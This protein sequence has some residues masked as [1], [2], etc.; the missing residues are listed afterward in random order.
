MHR[1]GLWGWVAS[2]ALATAACGSGGRQLPASGDCTLPSVTNTDTITF[3][4]R[5]AR[6]E[7][8]ITEADRPVTFTA[9]QP[10]ESLLAATM[11]TEP[12]DNALI[13]FTV[14]GLSSFPASAL[15]AASRVAGERAAQAPAWLDRLAAGEAQVRALVREGGLG[16]P[17]PTGR[18]WRA[19]TVEPAVGSTRN[20]WIFTDLAAQTQAQITAVL[21]VVSPHAY[22]YVHDVDSAG[23]DAA[24]LENLAAK[25]ESTIYPRLIQTFG[26]EP[27]VDGNGRVIVLLSHHVG[28]KDL[29]GLFIPP[30][31][32]ADDTTALRRSNEAEIF[33]VTTP[34]AVGATACEATAELLPAILAHELEHLINFNERVLVRHASQEDV[35]ADEGLAMLAQD[36]AGYGHTT[37]DVASR[38]AS[39][40]RIVSGYSLTRWEDHAAGNYGGSYL[41]FR[42]LADRFG[43]GIIGPLVQTPLTG[44]ANVQAATGGMPF[45][46]LERDWRLALALSH[47]AIVPVEREP[48]Y[49]FST[50]NL[51]DYFRVPLGYHVGLF[52][53]NGGILNL[54]VR[55][56]GANYVLMGPGTG[57]NVTLTVTA[58]FITPRVVVIRH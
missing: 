42:Y 34:A 43:E 54:T 22:V 56:H 7:I 51:N 36:I 14:T 4:T 11:N 13:Q 38:I 30:D 18:S 25:W 15:T 2:L 10:S 8:S 50:L 26:T 47:T 40:L 31:L 53:W 5:P 16:R 3:A 28:D 6:E 24:L 58:P 39:Y 29:L 33:Y 57:A 21:R 37:G 20:F 44:E 41:F 1:V 55:A 12:T 23:I 9:L 32:F 35:W 19:L 46:D 45:I 49:H 48:R 17:L 27:D 52:G